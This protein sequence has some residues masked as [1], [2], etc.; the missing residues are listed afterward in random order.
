MQNNLIQKQPN[1]NNPLFNHVSKKYKVNLLESDQDEIKRICRAKFDGDNNVVLRE[2]DY[3]L[4]SQHDLYLLRPHLAK[5][6]ELCRE[7]ESQDPDPEPLKFQRPMTKEV[8]IAIIEDDRSHVLS[9]PKYFCH[10]L[11][12]YLYLK[13]KQRNYRKRSIAK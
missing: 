4:M 7:I 5:I 9:K 6:V 13:R 12:S 11:K 3:Y 2:L 8:F 10:D 1:M